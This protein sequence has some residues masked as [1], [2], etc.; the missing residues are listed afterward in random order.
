MNS[1]FLD[2]YNLLAQMDVHSDDFETVFRNYY[3]EQK[4][5]GDAIADL[6]LD[7]FTEMCDRVGDDHF[8][9]RKKV[10]MKIETTFPEKYRS[11]Y[12]LVTYTLVPYYLAKE[13]GHIQDRILDRL[14]DGVSSLEDL[15]LRLAES[16]I[17]SEFVPW[18]KQHRIGVDR[19][20]L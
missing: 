10:E 14:T 6:S 13:A 17:D 5:N 1:G 8:L 9:F 11:R 12:G 7:N 20:T 15:D 19:F 16:L 3:L 18:L 4:R 2:I